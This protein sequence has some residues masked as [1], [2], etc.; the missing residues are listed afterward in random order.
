MVVA[1]GINVRLYPDRFAGDTFDIKPAGVNFG[2][3]VRNYNPFQSVF[4]HWFEENDQ[5]G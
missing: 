1:I 4:S 5:L 3:H 2:R